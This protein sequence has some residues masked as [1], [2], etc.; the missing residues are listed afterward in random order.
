MS[1]PTYYPEHLPILFFSAALRSNTD[2]STLL[3]D[4]LYLIDI[5]DYIYRLDS[6]YKYILLRNSR[7]KHH[8]GNYKLFFP[9]K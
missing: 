5:I 7:V 1:N 6:F 2:I 4:V 8:L 9:R 3:D